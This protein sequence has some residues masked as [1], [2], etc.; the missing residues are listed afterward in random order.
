VTSTEP[1]AIPT[2]IPDL[3]DIPVTRLAE[4]GGPG[5]ARA[6]DEYRKR[7]AAAGLPLS[8]FQARI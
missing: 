2:R 6:L 1:P 8:S 5:L 7:I 3:R 4:F